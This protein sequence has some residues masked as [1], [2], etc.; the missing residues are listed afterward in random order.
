M[1]VDRLLETGF[2]PMPKPPDLQTLKLSA[3]LAEADFCHMLS[4]LPVGICYVDPGRAEIVLANESAASILALPTAQD[5]VGQSVYRFVL[6]DRRPQVDAYLRAVAE[7]APPSRFFPEPLVSASDQPIDLEI[8]VALLHLGG[9]PV[10]QFVFQEITDRARAEAALRESEDLFRSLSET[11]DAAI[12]LFRGSRN[13]HVNAAACRITGYSY[14]ELVAMPFWQVLHPDYRDLVQARGLARQEGEDVPSNYKVAIVTKSGEVRWLQYSG[15]VIDYQGQLAV[16][17]TAYDVTPLVEAEQA[18]RAYA[19]RLEALSQIDRLGLMGLSRRE[20]AK[21]AIHPIRSLVQCHRASIVEVDT[22]TDSCVMLAVSPAS[23]TAIPPGRRFKLAR[24]LALHD[25]LK[26]DVHYVPDIDALPVST[27]LQQEV[28]TEGIRSYIAVPLL[29]QQKLVGVLNLGSTEPWAFDQAQCSAAQEVAQRLAV[30]LYDAHL[31]GALVSSRQRQ[32]ELSRRLERLQEAERQAIAREL[33][34]EF[35]QTLTALSIHLQLAMHGDAERQA[36]HLADTQ[37]LVEDLAVRVRRMSLDLRPPM[38]DDLGL[39]PTLLWYFERIAQQHQLQVTFEQ[40]G[41]ERRF[42]PEIESAIFRIV[43]EA[44]TNVARHA[45]TNAASVR[46][47]S[48][49]STLSAQIEDKGQGFD[50]DQVLKRHSSSGLRG[51]QERAHL[52]GG[53]LVIE[54]RPGAGACL[55]ALLPLAA[56]AKPAEQG[57]VSP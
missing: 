22:A 21:A 50:L 39:L 51:M 29:A 11:T 54:A 15:N 41:I 13:L 33:H 25:G 26:D 1:P 8:A 43:Q 31:F 23:A 45:Q 44:L 5:L 19:R 28:R 40:H 52:L 56:R 47:W 46:L 32:E 42:D 10:I 6:S 7:E 38:L 57:A 3:L 30:V 2:D 37:R 48:D 9:H 16:L 53:A 34:D 55:T 20:I 18:L 24:W 49:A 14:Q 4:L 12:F 17:G 27:A 36:R 35:G